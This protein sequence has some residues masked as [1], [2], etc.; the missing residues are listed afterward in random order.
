M[1]DP[2]SERAARS[3]SKARRCLFVGALALA[4]ALGVA[5]CGSSSSGSSSGSG[6]GGSSGGKYS[7]V[8]TNYLTTNAWR[9]Q[10]QKTVEIGA[11]KEPFASKVELSVHNSELS[12]QSQIST[13][14]SI[15]AEKPDAII[16]EAASP[17]AI[18]PTIERACDAGIV[19]VTFDAP[20]SAPC[21]FQLNPEFTKIAETIGA[22]YGETIKNGTIAM[23]T[24]LAGSSEAITI[25]EGF[26]KGL[27]K[28]PG[29]KIAAKFEGAFDPG[30]EQQ[31]L[32][33]VL[34]KEPNLA[35]AFTIN[36]G[37]P[38]ITAFQQA[39]GRMPVALSGTAN[40]KGS[41]ECIKHASE[42]VNCL[43]FIASPGVS[44]LALNTALE[45]L[46]EKIPNN[47]G[48]VL[49]GGP[50]G[51]F[52]ANGTTEVPGFPEAQIEQM[53]EGKNVFPEYSPG[54][55]VPITPPGSPVQ[56]TA[57]EVEGG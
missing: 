54:M 36:A 57:S 43:Y 5:A 21:A 31:A 15:I 27:A 42:G 12:A 44:L 18:N 2:R 32:A 25:D 20:A 3:G 16:M 24:G 8:L 28:F 11:E 37:Y 17:S 10:M 39:V 7:V 1:F 26:E 6:S 52:A 41:Q 9:Q 19:V 45:V 53:K 46:E 23:D 51:A 47:G 33:S 40:N 29:V 50:G 35:S 48:T 49:E 14:N 34:A 4:L 30:K 22:W 13:L 38:V 56:V 55:V